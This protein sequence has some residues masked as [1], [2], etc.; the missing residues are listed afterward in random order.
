MDID[1]ES[2]ETVKNKIQNIQAKWSLVKSYRKSDKQL[3]IG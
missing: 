3:N 1:P 2:F